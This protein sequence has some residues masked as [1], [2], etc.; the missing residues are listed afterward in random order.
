MSNYVRNHGC[1]N[2][3]INSAMVLSQIFLFCWVL[4][5]ESRSLL[6]TSAL[7]ETINC[8]THRG[9]WAM[10][11]NSSM[12]PSSCL[13][14]MRYSLGECQKVRPFYAWHIEKNTC[15][16]PFLRWSP[17]S[18]CK[19]LNG[20]SIMVVGDSINEEFYFS[21][22]SAMLINSSC[23]T[24]TL[25]SVSCPNGPSFTISTARNDRVTIIS[26][27]IIT[28]R[29]QHMSHDIEQ[30]WHN[31]I[32]SENISIVVLNRGAHYDPDSKF[33][34]E[35][36]K[37]LHYLTR[38][39]PHLTVIFRN[40]PPGHD[41]HTL[42]FDSAPLQRPQDM[43]V[44]AERFPLY[45]WHD[46]HRQNQLLQELLIEYFPSVILMDVAYS[47][48]LRADSHCDYL[49]YCI[50][51]PLDNWVRIFFNIINLLY[52]HNLEDG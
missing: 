27:D 9:K 10:L 42:N 29:D 21:L 23:D 40:T 19:I 22:L 46:F 18:M 37:T 31:R 3:C 1:L 14:E 36:N 20:R 49:H 25:K 32:L 39:H 43:T 44:I 6:T 7:Q 15:M 45:H 51:G 47:T 24:S 35:L 2:I 26:G 11:L 34:A 28:P 13:H 38:V 4:Q 12:Y 48:A 30:G 33:L 41:N 8:W 17:N 52:G 5:C 16:R 50:P